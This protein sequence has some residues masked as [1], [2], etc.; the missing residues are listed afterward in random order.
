MAWP[1]GYCF[2]SKARGTHARG[3]THRHAHTGTHTEHHTLRLSGPSHQAPSVHDSKPHFKSQGSG[4]GSETNSVWPDTSK[5]RQ[6]D[7]S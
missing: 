1:Q 3:C 4:T 6:R 2:Y 5:G 7:G